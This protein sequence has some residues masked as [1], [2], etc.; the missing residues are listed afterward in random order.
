MGSPT[1]VSLA[2]TLS[3]LGISR[4]QSSRWQKLAS[5]P[6]EFEQTFAGA[7]RPS[8]TRILSPRTSNPDAAEMAQYDSETDVLD[9]RSRPGGRK[10]R[11]TRT[12]AGL[13]SVIGGPVYDFISSCFDP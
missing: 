1:K 4:N 12:A 3:D 2:G 5:I 10:P 13:P 6:E 11:T 7:D 8:T 9:W